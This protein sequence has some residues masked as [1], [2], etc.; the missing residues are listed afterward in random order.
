MSFNYAIRKLGNS[1]YLVERVLCGAHTCMPIA[2][3]W[4]T[5]ASKRG[6]PFGGHDVHQKNFVERTNKF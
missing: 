3:L 6:G 5:L 1:T 4:I 2:V